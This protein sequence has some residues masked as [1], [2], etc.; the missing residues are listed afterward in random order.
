MKR[1]SL[2][3]FPLALLLSMSSK[4]EIPPWSARLLTGGFDGKVYWSGVAITLAPHWKTYWRVP[5][6]GGIAPQFDVT[7]DNLKSH[8]IDYPLPQQYTD[9][10]GS[11][12]GYKDEV[13]FPLAVEP[14][15]LNKPVTIR[16]KSF[17]GV[18]DVVCVPAKFDAGLTFD[19]AK[20]AA[21]DQALIAQWQDKVPAAQA[22][23]PVSKAVAR[24]SD[25]KL[26]LQLDIAEAVSFIF[27]EGYPG[28]Y[29]SNTIKMRGLITMKVSGAKSLE[30]LRSTPLRI[31]VQPRYGNAK[32]LEQT[33][34]VE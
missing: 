29:F 7:G 31:T 10:A 13:I 2:L 33:I 16:L 34:N 32:A 22:M 6:D 23:G 8:R 30:E 15:D 27:V 26:E 28:H 1:R 3:Q 18:C 21:P 9:A 4:A 12:I 5:G 24:L 17:F 25:G 20:S 19:P 14:L 11:T